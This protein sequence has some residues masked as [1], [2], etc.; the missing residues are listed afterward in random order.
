MRRVVTCISWTKV[1]RRVYP[2]REGFILCGAANATFPFNYQSPPQHS[3][4]GTSNCSVM[5]EFLC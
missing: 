4:P 1:D 3:A 5:S 2:V